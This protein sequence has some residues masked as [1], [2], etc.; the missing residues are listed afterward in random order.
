M[1]AY[2]QLTA[3]L[4][5]LLTN[6]L[7][8]LGYSPLQVYTGVWKQ[9]AIPEFGKY[10]VQIAP[11]TSNVWTERRISIREI[12]HVLRVDVFLLVKNFSEWPALYGETGPDLGLF[13]LVS[14]T[15]DLLR[16]ATF[17]GFTLTLNE[18]VGDTTFETGAATGF[19]TGPRTWV[20]RAR[21][22]YTAFTEPF[23]PPLD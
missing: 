21:V 7:T 13:Q 9:R 5:T 19:E 22:P 4:E 2:S 12:Q 8:G 6:G 14:D 1:N 17:D 11:P 23:C 16:V 15:K 18:L 10:Y 20:H 3:A